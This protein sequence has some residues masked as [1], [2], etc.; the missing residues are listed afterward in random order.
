MTHVLNVMI[1]NTAAAHQ[2]TNVAAIMALQERADPVKV[3]M[4][5]CY[6]K[7][8]CFEQVQCYSLPPSHV[9]SKFLSFIKLSMMCMYT[10]TGKRL[11]GS[12]QVGRTFSANFL[13]S[14]NVCSISTADYL[15][16]MGDLYISYILKEVNILYNL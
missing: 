16:L 13:C 3:C 15:Y 9:Y 8:K 5:V 11:T 14:T 2:T 7:R 4:Y 1:M 12:L 10:L 6:Y